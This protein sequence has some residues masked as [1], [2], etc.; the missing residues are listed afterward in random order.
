[1]TTVP[2]RSAS[3]PAIFNF[4][5][6]IF[7]FL[8]SDWLTIR[9]QLALGAIFIAAALPKIADPPSFAHM[10]YN[11]RL[12]PAGLINISAIVLPWVELVCGL[13]LVLG[14]WRGPARTIIAAMLVVFIVAIAFNLFRNNAIDCGCFDVTAVGLTHEERLADMRMVI[15]RDIGMLLM[16][17]QLWLAE[18]RH[19]TAAGVL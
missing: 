19:R 15:L 8:K 3:R 7:N 10:I 1:M 9:V 6:S 14:V 16:A 17:A 11:Y 12:L 13:A 18:R 2:E 4:Q 5:F